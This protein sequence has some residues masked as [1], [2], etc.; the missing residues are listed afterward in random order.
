MYSKQRKAQVLENGDVYEREYYVCS[1]TA[2][3]I[4]VENKCDTYMHED[5][6]KQKEV[7]DN[8]DIKE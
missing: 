7:L 5:V 4:T 2:I 3:G 1:C 8:D 6:L